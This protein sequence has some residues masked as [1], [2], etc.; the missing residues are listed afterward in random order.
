MRITCTRGGFGS[1]TRMARAVQPTDKRG[2][3]PREEA[4][5]GGS[6]LLRDTDGQYAIYPRVKAVGSTRT[7][8]SSPMVGQARFTRSAGRVYDD[9]RSEPGRWRSSATHEGDSTRP[10]PMYAQ[11]LPRQ[12]LTGHDLNTDRLQVHCCSLASVFLP[13]RRTRAT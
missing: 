9:K 5:G 8:P 3:V 10:T 1:R 6:Y 4:E 13:Q 7:V 2:S 12:A 11:R